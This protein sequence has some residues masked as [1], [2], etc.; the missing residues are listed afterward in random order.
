MGLLV[1]LVNLVLVVVSV[2]LVKSAIVRPNTHPYVQT[3]RL[4]KIDVAIAELVEIVGSN[5][6]MMFVLMLALV[7]AVVIV[8]RVALVM[9]IVGFHSIPPIIAKPSSTSQP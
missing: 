1:L 9:M 8:M 2:C 7:V 3:A 5:V 6:V 4:V